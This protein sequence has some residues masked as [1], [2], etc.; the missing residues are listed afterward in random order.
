MRASAVGLA[1][2]VAGL[3]IG[4]AAMAVMSGDDDGVA[5]MMA[6]QE[7]AADEP[8]DRGG[9]VLVFLAEGVTDEQRQAIEAALAR[10]E[11]EDYEYWDAEA[12]LAEARRIFADDPEMLEKV[13]GGVQVP[14]SYRLL[15]SDPDLPTA[16][17]VQGDLQGLPGVLRVVITSAVQELGE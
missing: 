7:S 12:S 15:L 5:E 8:A 2:L 10:P 16:T 9:H 17:V 3:G 6:A 14:Q 13:D 11:V 4:A 1:C